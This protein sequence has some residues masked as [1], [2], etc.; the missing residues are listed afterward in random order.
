MNYYVEANGKIITYNVRKYKVENTLKILPQYA[1]L[2]IQKTDKNIV[3]FDNTF[4]IEDDPEYI[5][6]KE[7][8]EEE[9]IQSLSMT[10]SDFF[11]STIKA[12]GADS[13][14]LLPIIQGILETLPISDLEKK[15]AVNNYN[16]ALNFY[17]KHALFTLLSDVPITIGEHIITISK[18]QWDSFFDRVS[19]RDPEAYKEL[20]PTVEN[21]E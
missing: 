3:E 17:R 4:Y 12:W 15:I 19:K 16:N 8:A 13:N 6:K 9:R 7:A 21:Q 1:D 18:E 2:P 10:R 14:D 20:L 11:D 5:S